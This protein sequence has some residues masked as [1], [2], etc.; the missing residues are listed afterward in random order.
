MGRSDRRGRATAAAAAAEASRGGGQLQLVFFQ[1]AVL[2]VVRLAQG[3]AASKVRVMDDLCW[4]FIL[5]DWRCDLLQCWHQQLPVTGYQRL[6]VLN[7]PL[8]AHAH[9]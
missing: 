6:K 8:S 7:G 5:I 2:H 3:A 4:P 9:T 1:D